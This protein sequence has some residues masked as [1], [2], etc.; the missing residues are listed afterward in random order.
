MTTWHLHAVQ[1]PD[2]EAVEDSWLTADGWQN[3]PVRDAVGFLGRDAAAAPPAVVTFDQDP[4]EDPAV[5]MHP[6]AVVIGGVRIV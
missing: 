2:G 1:L 3:Q 6:A 5:L 4:R